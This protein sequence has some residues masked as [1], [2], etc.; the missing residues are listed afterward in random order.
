MHP[1]G[2]VRTPQ[3]PDRLS[4]AVASIAAPASA[5]VHTPKGIAMAVTLNP[6]LNFRDG[7]RQVMEFYASVLGGE[8][9]ISTFAE[10]GGMGQEESEQDK[11]MHSQLVTPAGLTL[12][13]ADVPNAMPISENGTVSLSGGP[14]DEDELRGYW[15]G[16]TAGGQ[17]AVPLEKAPWGDFFGM[18]TDRFGITWMVNIAGTAG[19]NA[20]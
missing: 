10:F 2:L 12:M 13:A 8:P 9:T 19:G 20:S 11:V 18:L 7:A 15:D 3:S 1:G 5:G 14:D 16:L 6:Y 17:V 4:G